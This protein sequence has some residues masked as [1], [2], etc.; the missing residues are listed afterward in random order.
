VAGLLEEIEGMELKGKTGAVFG[1]Y[2]WAE[3]ATKKITESLANSG[4]VLPLESL[5]CQWVPDKEILAQC[6]DFGKNF[7]SSLK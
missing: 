5:K 2:G 4:F 6:I 7:A 3:K 1:S